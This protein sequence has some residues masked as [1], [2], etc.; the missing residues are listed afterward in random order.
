MRAKIKFAWRKI[1]SLDL[2][3]VQLP[4]NRKFGF[5]FSIVFTLLA[6][7]LYI[8]GSFGLAKFSVIIS[9]LLTAITM[10]RPN[11]LLPINKAWM[12][13]GLILG[14]IVSP[15]VLGIVFFGLFTPISLIMRMLKRDELRLRSQ[16]LKSFWINR[17]NTERRESEF[18]QQ[19]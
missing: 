3:E 11:I 16:K 12:G 15:L 14:I 18:T 9:L 8:T 5:F 7:Y 19:F 2:P 6:L 4:S 1:K 10:F 13:I 17:D